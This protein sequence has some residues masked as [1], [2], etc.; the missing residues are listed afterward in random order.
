MNWP[1]V[2]L[3]DVA[4]KTRGA[5]VSGPFGSSIGSRFFVE[6]GVPIIRGNNLTKGKEKFIDKDF[7]FLTESKAAEFSNCIAVAED[8]VITAAGSIGQVGIIPK[9]SS[10]EKY[11]ISNKQIRVRIDHQRANPMFVYY[12]LSSPKIVRYLENMNNGGAVPLL[13]LSIIRK[14]PIPL[15]LQRTQDRIVSILSAFDNLIENNCRRIALLEQAARLLYREWFMYLRFPGHEQAKIIDGVPEGWARMPLGSLLTL[16]RGF[17]LPT[18]RREEGTVPVIASTGRVG[19][20]DE[21][22]VKGPGV[23]TGRSGSLGTVLYVQEDFWPLNT[24]LWGRE[25]KQST[26]LFV[27]FLLL[28]LRLEQFNGG[29]AVPTLNRNDVHKI[30]VLCPP[31]AVVN[32]LL[33]YVLPMYDQIKKLEQQSQKLAR[34][35]NLLLPRVMNGEIAV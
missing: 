14:V 33:D 18:Y 5:I 19:F 34:A 3:Q 9:I 25:F 31:Q 26:P 2:D 22:R 30:K 16:Q 23:V 24:T 8:I 32:S 20:H 15:P 12:W 1:L 13:N 7:V 27:Y 11:V 10:F 29:A 28:G 17:D 21:P 35:R 4:L 6:E